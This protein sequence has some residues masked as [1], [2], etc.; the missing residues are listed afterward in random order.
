MEYIWVM[1]LSDKNSVMA[2]RVNAYERW[3]DYCWKCKW[4]N[5]I[6]IMRTGVWHWIWILMSNEMKWWKQCDG[7]E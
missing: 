3:Y 4:R 1:K 6:E 2:L 7:I 5:E